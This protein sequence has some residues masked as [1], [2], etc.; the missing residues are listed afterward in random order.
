MHYAAIIFKKYGY[1]ALCTINNENERNSISIEAEN[2]FLSTIYI[3]LVQKLHPMDLTLRQLIMCQ[4]RSR[5]QKG[6]FTTTVYIYL[7]NE[8]PNAPLANHAS[9]HDLLCQ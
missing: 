9:I 1:V 7:A 3:L 2:T 8:L 6:S 4:M 5:S